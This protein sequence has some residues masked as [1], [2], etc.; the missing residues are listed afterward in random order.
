MSFQV[1]KDR[2]IDNSSEIGIK[3]MGETD[4]N[5]V[6]RACSKR[7]RASEVETAAVALCSA[8]QEKLK[9]TLWRPFWTV[10]DEDGK[11]QVFPLDP[12]QFSLCIIIVVYSLTFFRRV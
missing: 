10:E 1:L 8:W 2:Q 6:K 3:Q 5:V 7:F 12:P 9:N 4:L 11:L